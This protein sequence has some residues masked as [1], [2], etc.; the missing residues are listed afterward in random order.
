MQRQ[1]SSRVFSKII[2]TF[3]LAALSASVLGSCTVPEEKPALTLEERIRAD[4]QQ[5]E[6]L[7]QR[8]EEKIQIKNETE[9]TVFL[10][11]I[12]VKLSQS[13]LELKAAPVGVFLI[14]NP[15]QR[16]ANY[17][18]PGNRIYISLELLK[19][20]EFENEAAAAIAIELSHIYK[21]W[22]L[23]KVAR[24]NP[25]GA[26]GPIVA[27]KPKFFGSRGLFEYTD[28]EWEESLSEA[29]KLMYRAGYDPRG[30]V[31]F[32]KKYEKKMDPKKLSR[33]L[34]TV[35]STVVSLAP[36]RNPVVRT[37]AFMNLRQRIERL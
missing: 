9:V 25:V 29:V 36:L 30:M 3:A 6:G 23:E 8:F 22:V 13:Q 15:N 4:N 5:G 7:S 31:T 32:L 14:S 12:A 1:G 16:W 17:S 10:R 18:L 2:I 27:E 33:L 34:E 20:I 19:E 21:R 11:K 35:R 26:N 24:R 37:E 28:A